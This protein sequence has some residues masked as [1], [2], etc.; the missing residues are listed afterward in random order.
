[1]SGGSG[2]YTT[3]A[4]PKGPRTDLLNKLFG[5][6]PDN[7]RPPAQGT[8]SKAVD[9]A[10]ARAAVLAIATAKVDAQGVGGIAPSDGQQQG[11]LG[12][13]PS[14]VDLNFGNSP[15]VSK[16]TWTSANSPSG[17]SSGGPAHPYA[18]DPSSPGPGKTE[19]LDK[20]ADPGVTPNDMKLGIGDAA[21]F[22]P[23]DNT[24]SPAATGPAIAGANKLGTSG[25]PGKSGA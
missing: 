3:Y 19:G 22:V 14:K 5:N 23:S 21:G 17:I 18:P 16:V 10:S 25:L 20:T 1:M 9:E 2:K 7:V 15:D 12:L 11:D 13:Y 8:S 6:A 4:S 24:K